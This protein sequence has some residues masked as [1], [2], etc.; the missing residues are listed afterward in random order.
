M[1][2]RNKDAVLLK[3]NKEAQVQALRELGFTGVTNSTPLSEIA[4]YMRWAGGLRDIRLAAY[5]REQHV[6]VGLTREEWASMGSNVR[7]KYVKLGLWIRCDRTEFIIASAD[8]K[9]GGGSYGFK[10]GGYGV[11]LR[12]VQNYGGTNTGLYDVRTGEADTQAAV[13]QLN[14]Y[15]DS[16]NILGAPACEAAWNY[17][18]ANDVDEQNNPNRQWYLP[19]ITQLWLMSKYRTQIHEAFAVFFS[20]S[21]YFASDAYWSSTEYG[22]SSSWFL[23]MGSGSMYHDTRNNTY[24]VRPVASV[25]SVSS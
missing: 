7:S 6:T 5:H 13:T 2:D 10:W 23:H 16:Q 25:S 20:S 15:T 1:N 3:L 24:R 14:G 22:S 11:D 8:C 21:S 17:Q 4:E 19:S 18:V 12:G 9:T